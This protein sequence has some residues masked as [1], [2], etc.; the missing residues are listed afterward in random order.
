MHDFTA[1]TFSIQLRIMCEETVQW[2]SASL[3][4]SAPS[5][6]MMCGR[7]SSAGGSGLL[8]TRPHNGWAAVIAWAADLP[9]V[10]KHERQTWGN[11]WRFLTSSDLDLWALLLKIDT[12]LSVPWGAFI[13]ILTFLLFCFRVTS[14]CWTDGRTRHVM[15]LR[16]AHNNTAIHYGLSFMF[17]S[18]IS[19][20]VIFSEN[21]IYLHFVT[22]YRLRYN[23]CSCTCNYICWLHVFRDGHGVGKRGDGNVLREDGSQMCGDQ[24]RMGKILWG[25][26]GDRADF[27]YRVTLYCKSLQ[28]SPFLYRK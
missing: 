27:H 21:A 28:K 25:W 14:P 16:T 24:A 1:A 2:F 26:D 4:A 7:S 6:D 8:Q 15:R 13:P 12:P 10:S 9:L 18:A 11:F 17:R 20:V 22:D 19:I 3:F 5:A 23:T